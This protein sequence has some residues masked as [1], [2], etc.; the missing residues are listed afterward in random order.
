MHL[1]TANGPKAAHNPLS[2]WQS[3][4]M[5]CKIFTVPLPLSRNPAMVK[6]HHQN[7]TGCC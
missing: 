5:E 7:L 1:E 3:P 4:F 2:I 6:I